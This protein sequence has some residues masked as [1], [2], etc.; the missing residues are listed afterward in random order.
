[1]CVT[2][3]ALVTAFSLAVIVL[4]RR[5]LHVGCRSLVRMMLSGAKA[6]WISARLVWLHPYDAVGWPGLNQ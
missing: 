5:L 1:M 3:R 2:A 6:V 4:F